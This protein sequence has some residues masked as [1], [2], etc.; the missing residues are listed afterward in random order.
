MT[1][2]CT[3]AGLKIERQSQQLA[4]KLAAFQQHRRDKDAARAAKEEDRARETKVRRCRFTPGEPRVDR[5]WSHRMKLKYDELLS[6]LA[7]SFKLR[8]YKKAEQRLQNPLAGGVLRTSTRP[9]LN[10]PP[11]YLMSL[12]PLALH[13]HSTEGE[14]TDLLRASV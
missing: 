13:K 10:P 14:S 1:G 12:A 4:V 11:S 6:T 8:R 5:A 9:T 2:P 3:G 7:H